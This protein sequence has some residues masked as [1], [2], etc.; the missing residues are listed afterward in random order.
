[1]TH[2][3]LPDAALF[4]TKVNFTIKWQ[5]LSIC[6]ALIRSV[7]VHVYFLN[8]SSIK[9]L[10][11]CFS[12]IHYSNL[13]GHFLDCL[14]RKRPVYF[15]DLGWLTVFAIAVLVRYYAL[16]LF[17]TFYIQLLRIIITK[18]LRYFILS[19]YN[20]SYEDETNKYIVWIS[21]DNGCK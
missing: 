1:M 7:C 21:T 10:I 19:N 9:L 17:K 16:Q 5:Q 8:K 12:Q 15:K 13:P 18:H 20:V 4:A 2:I 14:E 6:N 11:T 3:Q